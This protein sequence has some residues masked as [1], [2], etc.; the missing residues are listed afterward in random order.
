LAEFPG[1]EAAAG[2]MLAM[3][4]VRGEAESAS[5]PCEMTWSPVL[6]RAGLR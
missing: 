5:V 4:A 6:R 3:E 2:D 1:G